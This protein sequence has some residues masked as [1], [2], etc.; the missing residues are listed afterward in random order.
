MDHPLLLITLGL[1]LALGLSA[2]RLWRAARL[3]RAARA[4]YLGAVDALLRDRRAR[5]DPSGFPRL[6]GRFEGRA[7]ELRAI[8]DALTFRKLPA[9]WLLATL[10]E[11][12]PLRG[13]TR[14]MLRPTGQEP[15]STFGALPAEISP[16]PGFP[17]HLAMRS[18]APEDLPPAG[19][20]L[21]LA[22]LFEDPALKE[23]VLSPRGLRLVHLAEEAS[24]GAY[25]LFRD[26]ELGRAPARAP[27]AR[28]LLETL[29]TMSENLARAAR[30]A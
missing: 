26:A 27:R 16:P 10:T 19:F 3:R 21:G 14:L 5:L 23:I 2:R 30:P 7:V 29:L 15:F 9:L 13:E 24:R 4:G 8:P 6:A 28:A 25:L 12:Q 1:A 18:T 22:G 17:E 11:P 20:L